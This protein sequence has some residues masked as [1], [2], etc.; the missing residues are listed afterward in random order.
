MSTEH[1]EP[2]KEWIY[3]YS[4]GD[5]VRITDWDDLEHLLKGEPGAV[6]H[7]KDQDGEVICCYVLVMSQGVYLFYPVG[8]MDPDIFRCHAY[9]PLPVLATFSSMQILNNLQGIFG[10]QT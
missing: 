9:V 10:E 2:A 5:H 8:A 7:P 3:I 6:V 4:H 1:N